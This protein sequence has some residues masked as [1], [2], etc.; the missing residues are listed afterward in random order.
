[1]DTVSYSHAP[2]NYCR[3]D[4]MLHG[5]KLALNMSISKKKISHKQRES[6]ERNKAV[7]RGE[8]ERQFPEVCYFAQS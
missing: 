6:Q 4:H 2:C 5:C 7:Q 3:E 8:K 1:M